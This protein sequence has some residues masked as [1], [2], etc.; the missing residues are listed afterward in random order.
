MAVGQILNMLAAD[1]LQQKRRTEELDRASAMMGLRGTN[2]SEN[3]IA[4]VSK[5]HQVDPGFAVV[6][7]ADGQGHYTLSAAKLGRQL[8]L[9]N[10]LASNA[11][12]VESL[13]IASHAAAGG[14]SLDDIYK[15]EARRAKLAAI[16]RLRDELAPEQEIGAYDERAD[17]SPVRMSGGVAYNRYDPRKPIVGES[18]AVDATASLRRA[19]AGVQPSIS[20]KNRAAAS[21]S[22]AAASASEALSKLRGTQHLDAETRRQFVETLLERTRD[23]LLGADIANRR[24][25]SKPE[26]LK[27]Q[28]NDGNSYYVD[29]TRNPDGTFTYTPSNLGGRP[30]KAPAAAQ[31]RPTALASNIQTLIDTYPGMSQQEAAEYLTADPSSRMRILRDYRKRPAAQQGSVPAAPTPPNQGAPLATGSALPQ[32]EADRAYEQARAYIKRGVSPDK[33]KG[34]LRELGLD[35]GRL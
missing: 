10:A 20:E 13:R 5:L 16:Q 7:P 26:R 15:G 33:V 9:E 6:G 34:R 17:L 35:P 11:P 4:M 30:A 28:G 19:Q 1:Y 8:D 29:A 22:D 32:A 21:A 18:S 24:P 3:E 12:D 2:P 31:Q 14:A 23:P 25:V 27:V